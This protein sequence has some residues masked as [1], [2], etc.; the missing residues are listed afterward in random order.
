MS[1]EI[2][3]YTDYAVK[4]P[5]F[6]ID[7]I[8]SEIVKRDVKGLTNNRIKSVNI[9]GEHPL[10]RMTE[11]VLSGTQLDTSGFLP[12][13]AVVEADENEDLTTLGNGTRTPL[14]LTQSFVDECRAIP[15]EERDYE[16]LLSNLQ[17][18]K[19]EQAIENNKTISTTGEG[20]VLAELEGFFLR[21]TMFVS[22]WCHSVDERNIIG[23]VV[24]SILYD[25]KKAM[26]A[27][28]LKDTYLRTAKG[29]VNTN[30]GRIL[31]GQETS[32]D[33]INFFHNIT[34]TDEFPT[35]IML[36]NCDKISVYDAIQQSTEELCTM[37]NVD[38]KYRAA[39]YPDDGLVNVHEGEVVDE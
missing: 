38:S 12:A 39:G 24:R 27:R 30:F 36:D 34:V 31:H 8:K 15:I 37:I 16:G 29:L 21:E 25:M 10:V 26:R 17:L 19:I 6:F 28:S 9:T 23:N 1:N 14:I 22:V 11:T 3:K 7:Y 4:T 32:I 33:Y 5:D 20:A 18:D 35:K 2:T 13:I